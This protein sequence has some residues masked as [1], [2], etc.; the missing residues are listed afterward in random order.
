MFGIV[1]QVLLYR[2]N[3]SSLV[4]GCVSSGRLNSSSGQFP[5]LYL[6][7]HTYIHTY[8]HIRTYIYKYSYK[9]LTHKLTY[10]KY[11][12]TI[13][14]SSYTYIQGCMHIR[15]YTYSVSL[16]WTAVREWRCFCHHPII[17]CPSAY[18]RTLTADPSE[19]TYIIHTYI[20]DF[21]RF[22]LTHTYINIRTSSRWILSVGISHKCFS[23]P[24]IAFLLNQKTNLFTH[25]Y[26]RLTMKIF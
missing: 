16:T 20:H 18:C 24:R 2:I 19:S 5:K 3:I 26:T 11:L 21:T 13:L 7:T 14:Y 22:F 15:I 23:N 1:G 17:E 8:I 4:N 6:S 25:T 12:T 10:T 9:I